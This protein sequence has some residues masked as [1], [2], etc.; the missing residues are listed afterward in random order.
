M[1]ECIE[2]IDDKEQFEK[3]N[4]LIDLLMEMYLLEMQS[5][6]IK[7]KKKILIKEM[8]IIIIVNLIYYL[9]LFMMIYLIMLK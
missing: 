2:L 5:K 3:F 6:M 8:K 4:K 1:H 7:E 9:I